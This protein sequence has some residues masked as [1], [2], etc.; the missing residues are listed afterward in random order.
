MRMQE[1][2]QRLHKEEHDGAL[3]GVF[4]FIDWL[5]PVP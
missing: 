3:C 5:N 4:M 1:I 2:W